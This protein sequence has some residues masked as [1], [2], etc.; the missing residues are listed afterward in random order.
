MA[1]DAIFVCNET[2][3]FI[4]VNPVACESLGYSKEELLRLSIKEIDA[5][6]RGYEAFLKARNGQVKK[7]TFEVSG[8]K[9][10]NAFTSRDHREFFRWVEADE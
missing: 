10:W 4:D 6:P 9:R 7:I 1:K 2:G 5:D 8:E 3:R